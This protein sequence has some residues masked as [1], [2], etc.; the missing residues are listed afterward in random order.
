MLGFLATSPRL[1]ARV[2]AG[3]YNVTVNGQAYLFGAP[4]A[5]TTNNGVQLTTASGLTL[6]SSEKTVGADGYGA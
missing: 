2:L 5:F 4:P 1:L 6:A 3:S